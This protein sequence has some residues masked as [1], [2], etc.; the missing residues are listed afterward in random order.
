MTT[1]IQTQMERYLVYCE[2]ERRLSENTLKAY[3][4][5]LKHFECF[6][7]EKGFDETIDLALT[8]SM[9][10][11]YIAEMNEQ[12]AVKTVKRRLAALRGFCNWLEEGA[13]LLNNPFQ[14]M[15]L[16]IREPF[17]LPSAMTMKEVQLVLEAVYEKGMYYSGRSLGM[18]TQFL[19]YRDILVIEMLF[20]TG[21]RVQEL[22][23]IQFNDMDFFHRTVRIVGKGNKERIIYY[24]NDA[25]NYAMKQ[26]N[27]IRKEMC[28]G[29]DYLFVNKF[30]DP[31]SPQAV[32]NIIKKYVILADIKRNITPHSFRHTFATLLLEEGVDLRYIQEYLGHSSISTTQI[33]LHVAD[34]KALK[35]LAKKH[36]RRKIVVDP[37]RMNS[38]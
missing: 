14:Q 21:V 10:Q 22:C 16:R 3:Q 24:G 5:D 35:L 8:K 13:M 34:K 11:Q 32:R 23:S 7:T 31:L 38:D 30:G 29:G 2:K 15:K 17:R 18:T 1:V 28:F 27:W 6:L 12:Y 33:Y 19:H 36:P 26:Y 9:I 4:L 25:V 37:A 20:A